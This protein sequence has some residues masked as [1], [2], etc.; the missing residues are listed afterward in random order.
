MSIS[1]IREYLNTP[2]SEKSLADLY[3]KIQ[4]DLS[5]P[6]V[7][8]YI[9][10][11]GVFKTEALSELID[12]GL[13]RE[14]QNFM[15]EQGILP[16]SPDLRRYAE[17]KVRKVMGKLLYVKDDN[18][19]TNELINLN[20]SMPTRRFYVIGQNYENLSEEF[21]DIR[22]SGNCKLHMNIHKE[23]KKCISSR[24]T[25][26]LTSDICGLFLK[27]ASLQPQLYQTLRI[28]YNAEKGDHV[29]FRLNVDT[30]G[31]ICIRDHEK[32]TE[33]AVRIMDMPPKGDPNL[34]V[35]FIT[36]HGNTIYS[37]LN[38]ESI[39]IMYAYITP[40]ELTELQ[41]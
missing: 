15:T 39:D 2:S 21:N 31:L 36:Y 32:G 26:G 12:Q 40:L 30:R 22:I 14:N 41:V 7:R 10:R 1:H 9:N 33:E 29:E 25:S 27:Y 3:S 5:D 8:D 23:C 19:Y 24:I 11:S 16:V 13:S 37:R 38:D 17:V 28:H 18:F 20:D 6:V 35:K 34:P 4:S